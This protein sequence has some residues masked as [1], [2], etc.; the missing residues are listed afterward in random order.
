MNAPATRQLWSDFN[1]GLWRYIR[2]RVDS[3]ADADDVLQTVFLKVHRRKTQLRDEE[4][5]AG[6]IFRIASHAI[7]D[8]HRDRARRSDPPPQLERKQPTSPTDADQTNDEQLLAQCVRPFVETLPP[9]YRDALT[10]TELEG[11]TQAEA[12]DRAGLSLSGMK[13]RVQRGRVKLRQSLEQCCDITLDAR[14][15]IV[16]VEPRCDADSCVATGD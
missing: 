13:S 4:R 6:W 10:M 9:H 8:H 15:R 12:A 5:V 11:L 16:D 14:N 1:E 2:A 3:D 7:T